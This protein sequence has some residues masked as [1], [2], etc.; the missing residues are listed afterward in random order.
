MTKTNG[1]QQGGARPGAGRKPKQ[2][3]L[4]ERAEAARLAALRAFR[5]EQQAE[6]KALIKAAQAKVL[7]VLGIDN[8]EWK[9]SDQ[10]GAVETQIDGLAIQYSMKYGEIDLFVWAWDQVHNDDMGGYGWTFFEDLASL[11]EILASQPPPAD[12]APARAAAARV[13]L[14]SMEALDKPAPEDVEGE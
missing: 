5:R 10:D 13:T 12:D 11:G 7:A 1:K 8:T 4:R 2:L 9:P 6:R 14:P 3:P